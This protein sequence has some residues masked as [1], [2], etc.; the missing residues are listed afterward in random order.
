MVSWILDWIK[1]W[2]SFVL[3][4]PLP[5]YHNSTVESI[6]IVAS[7]HLGLFV[8]KQLFLCC[9]NA[10]HSV[11]KSSKIWRTIRLLIKYLSN[12][13]IVKPEQCLQNL[14]FF[15]PAMSAELVNNPGSNTCNKLMQFYIQGKSEKIR[16]KFLNSFAFKIWRSSFCKQLCGVFP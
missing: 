4:I 8:L 3:I 1:Q 15:W 7:V 5:C 16:N 2:W 11:T 6:P 13:W 10:F 14:I 12:D 9:L